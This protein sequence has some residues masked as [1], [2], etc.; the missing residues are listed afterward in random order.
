L[1]L[2]GAKK[3]KK[4]MSF[5]TVMFIC[6]L[7]MCICLL[8]TFSQKMP[9]L[10]TTLFLI[11]ITG[12]VLSLATYIIAVFRTKFNPETLVT[13]KITTPILIV[14]KLIFTALFTG[15]VLSVKSYAD[16]ILESDRI[17]LSILGVILIILGMVM[18]KI[19]Q[20]LD[21]GVRT[22][23]TL[24]ST[25]VWDKTN[26]FGGVLLLAQGI[27][28]I[29]SQLILPSYVNMYLTIGLAIADIPVLL[30]YSWFLYKIEPHT[31]DIYED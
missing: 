22:P 18:S 15:M 6:E 20:N 26:D 31:E 8:P 9:M 13:E 19:K 28:C 17:V 27:V 29:I 25:V 4:A 11:P 24:K 23:W 2:K 16:K 10:L 3:M 1:V 7:I 30:I 14:T 5:C 21:V 12:F